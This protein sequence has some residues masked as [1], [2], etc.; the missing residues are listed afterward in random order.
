MSDET[1]TVCGCQIQR[2]NSEGQGH[3]WKNV[4]REDLPADIVT[5]IECE[6]LDG[7]KDECGDY[8]ASNGQHYRWA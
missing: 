1:K 8:V 7:G 4:D 2:D 6:I 5:E 3:C